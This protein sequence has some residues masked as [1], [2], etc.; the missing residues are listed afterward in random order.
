MRYLGMLL[1]IGIVAGV[2]VVM[3]FVFNGGMAGP[4]SDGLVIELSPT[5]IP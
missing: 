1:L 4:A 2:A 3:V 5:R